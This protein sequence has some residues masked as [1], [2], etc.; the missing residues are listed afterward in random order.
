MITIIKG[1]W[2]SIFKPKENKT[3]ELD[4]YNPLK[5]KIGQNLSFDHDVD[6]KDVHFKIE[7]IAVY[8]TQI[9]RK[10]FKH[11]DY[12]LSCIKNNEHL[13]V[14]LR[15]IPN[16]RNSNKFKCD[17]QFLELMDSFSWDEDFY[18][19]VLCADSKT[20]NIDYDKKGQRLENQIVYWRVDDASTQ[21]RSEVTVLSDDDGN[22]V[23]EEKELLKYPIEYWDY[24][25]IKEN[26]IIEYLWVEKDDEIGSFDIFQ[27][28]EIHSDHVLLI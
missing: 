13:D 23:V 7:K 24:S 26:Q 2:N 17:F 25:R 18:N 1:L 19:N 11:I 12:F 9:H 3:L 20:F 10:N 8:S 15:L 4:F 28:I 16:P 5:A 14:R 22:G 6:Y 27:G 21:Y